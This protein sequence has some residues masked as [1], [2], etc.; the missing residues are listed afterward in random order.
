VS[1]I[2]ELSLFAFLALKSGRFSFYKYELM[3]SVSMND[4][5]FGEIVGD[6]NLVEVLFGIFGRAVSLTYVDAGIYIFNLLTFTLCDI[7]GEI[8]LVFRWPPPNYP[9]L[10]SLY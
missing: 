3:V 4:T 9:F 7:L 5:C 1:D 8:G 2:G 10:I 6:A